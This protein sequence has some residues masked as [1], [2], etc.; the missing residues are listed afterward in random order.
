[1]NDNVIDSV[2]DTRH[3]LND[4]PRKIVERQ[5][6]KMLEGKASDGTMFKKVDKKILKA[7]TDRVND[8]IKYLK[9]KKSKKRMISLKLQACG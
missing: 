6:E 2:D 1:M 9:T 4:E 7:Q 3:N 8:A 5:N